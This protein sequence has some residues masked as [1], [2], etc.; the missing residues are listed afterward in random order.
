MSSRIAKSCWHTLYATPYDTVSAA[1]V[2]VELPPLPRPVPLPL[3][4]PMVGRAPMIITDFQPD[5]PPPRPR[6]PRPPRPMP[7]EPESFAGAASSCCE[8][9]GGCALSTPAGMYAGIDPIG[10]GGRSIGAAG[11]ASTRWRDAA[12]SSVLG[13]PIPP[14]GGR[15][16]I[17]V[18]RSALDE[19]A[20]IE[21]ECPAFFGSFPFWKVM[22]DPP[23][24]CSTPRMIT[25]IPISVAHPR[26]Q[27]GKI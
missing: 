4:L 11:E 3:P 24:A 2:H 25:T 5:G 26:G 22:N 20:V 12:R 16:R 10:E 8:D 14:D 6:L 27:S 13:V 9:G 21:G 17:I 18:G 19:K 23:P 1:A 7:F 15:R